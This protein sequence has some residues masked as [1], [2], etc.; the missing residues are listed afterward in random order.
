VPAGYDG[1]I[2]DGYFVSESPSRINWLILRGLLVDSKPDGP[3]QTFHAG[4]RVYPLSEADSPP[5][6]EFISLSEKEFN[7]IHA[8]DVSFLRRARRGDPA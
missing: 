6:I 4:L 7:T 3:T 8:N 2:P 1:P 5:A